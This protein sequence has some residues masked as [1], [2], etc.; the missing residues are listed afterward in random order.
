MLDQ[1]ATAADKEERQE[2]MDVRKAFGK[3]AKKGAQ[4][5]ESPP[6]PPFPLSS[7]PLRAYTLL[8]LIHFPF[9]S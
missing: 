7:S 1:I 5:S 2:A 3:T 4:P 9:L 6:P 8:V